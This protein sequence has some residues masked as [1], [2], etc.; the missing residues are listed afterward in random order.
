MVGV[1]IAVCLLSFTLGALLAA[2][3][4]GLRWR[5]KNNEKLHTSPL[6]SPQAGPVYDV[7]EKHQDGML[8]L[9]ENPAYGGAVGD[10]L[11]MKDN[12]AYGDIKLH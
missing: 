1:S 3:I 9:K 5:R 7:V 6:D 4:Y 12:P 8:P 2:F 10:M 11:P